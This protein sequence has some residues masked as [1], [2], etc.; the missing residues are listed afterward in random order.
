MNVIAY[1]RNKKQADRVEAVSIDDLMKQSDV[2][3]INVSLNAE[4]EN[5]IS[6]RE[7]NLMKR[8][9][10]LINVSQAKVVETNALYRALLNNKIGGAG[11]DVVAGMKKG[12]PILRLDNTVFT[13]HAGSST[14]ESFRENLPKLVISDIENFLKGTPKN[15]IN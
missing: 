2:V 6:E 11:L 15:L 14:N 4:T 1:N 13:P 12:H 9:A 10:I 7:I 5:M 3:S 8:T